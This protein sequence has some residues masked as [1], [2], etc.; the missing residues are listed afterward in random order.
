LRI[1][2]YQLVLLISRM[3]FMC[4]R[5]RKSNK[6]KNFTSNFDVK[7]EKDYRQH[8]KTLTPQ[9]V[10]FIENSVYEDIYIYI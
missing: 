7:S 5:K 6:N 1:D 10:F 3:W 4:W 9:V 8:D 2:R